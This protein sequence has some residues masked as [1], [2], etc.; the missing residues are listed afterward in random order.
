MLQYQ[1]YLYKI[2]DKNSQKF[3]LL[4]SILIASVEQ[5]FI[6]SFPHKNAK[7]FFRDIHLRDIK[8]PNVSKF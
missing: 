6:S 1:C 5:L 7:Y 8:K 4:A 3:G 2:P